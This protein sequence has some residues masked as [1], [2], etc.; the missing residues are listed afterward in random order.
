MMEETKRDNSEEQ[1][2]FLSDG[3]DDGA[4]RL[5]VDQPG[6]KRRMIFGGL[7][8]FIEIAM[9]VVIVFLLVDK[10]YCG[11]DTIRSTPVPKCE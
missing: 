5:M 2:A 1:Q 9:A 4:L 11:R 10:P 6:E 8:L 3:D 7:R